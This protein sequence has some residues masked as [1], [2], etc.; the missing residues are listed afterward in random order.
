MIRLA[1]LS[2]LE[3][4]W[5][6]RQETSAL[7]KSRNIDQW[8]HQNPSRTTFIR[9]IESGEFFVYEKSGQIVGMIAIK[10][11][12]ERTY[13]TIYDGAWGDDLPYQTIHRL[14]VKKDYLGTSI[15]KEMLDYAELIAKQRNTPYIRI[16]T[17]F[18][19]MNAIRLFKNQGYILRGWIILEPGEGDLRRLAF[20]KKLED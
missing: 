20:D 6:L 3:A 16:D 5:T 4:I 1:T 8:Q 14:A 10:S 9:D 7:L 18:T 12:I 17:Y 2:D 15:A 13:L 11:G 19:N